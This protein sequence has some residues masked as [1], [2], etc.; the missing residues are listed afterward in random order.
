VLEAANGVEAMRIMA[1][2]TPRIALIV[3]DVVMPLMGGIELAQNLRELHP[4]L[5]IL[6]T[7]GYLPDA[8]M[9]DLGRCGRTNFL[10]KQYSPNEFVAK[11][12]EILDVRQ[13]AEGAASET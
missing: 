9:S 4:E 2:S 5:P 3:T 7:S 1:G 6:F 12:R 11:V 13:P 10:Q 8:K